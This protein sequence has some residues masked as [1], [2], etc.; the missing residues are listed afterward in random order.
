M[1]QNLARNST[2]RCKIISGNVLGLKISFCIFIIFV[3]LRVRVR[4]KVKV[5]S[6][7]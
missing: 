7:T 4:V 2:I 5:K 3:K 1:Y 6:Q